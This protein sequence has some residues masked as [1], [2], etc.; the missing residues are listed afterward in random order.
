M[1]N[2]TTFHGSPEKDDRPSWRGPS[3]A[4]PGIYFLHL[5]SV[6]GGGNVLSFDMD[7]AAEAI[8]YLAAL[9]DQALAL[10]SEISTA[11][12]AQAGADAPAGEAAAGAE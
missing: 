1:R 11:A 9:G 4:C 7:E 10:I 8:A 12:A 6:R 2:L 5:D 3:E